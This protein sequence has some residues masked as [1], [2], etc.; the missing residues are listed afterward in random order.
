VSINAIDPQRYY[1]LDEINTFYLEDI[2][3]GQAQWL[4]TMEKLGVIVND[5]V[6]LYQIAWGMVY[7]SSN[8]NTEF[9]Q[10]LVGLQNI[11]NTLNANNIYMN[12][13]IYCVSALL[14]LKNDEDLPYD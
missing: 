12:E 4:D 11:T 1:T 10:T 14:A 6:P 8:C 9:I 3:N 13:N 2:D 5:A 7:Y